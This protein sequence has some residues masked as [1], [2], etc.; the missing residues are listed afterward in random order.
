MKPAEAFD[1]NRQVHVPALDYLNA[2]DA[3]RE[4][5]RNALTHIASIEHWLD[6][7]PAKRVAY[8]QDVAREAIA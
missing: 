4:R 7:D 1:E 2:L 5:L 8:L 3:E 6:D